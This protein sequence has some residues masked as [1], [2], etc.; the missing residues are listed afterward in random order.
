[1][2]QSRLSQIYVAL[3]SFRERSSL[4]Q[5]WVEDLVVEDAS[6]RRGGPGQKILICGANRSLWGK[7]ELGYTPLN[8]LPRGDFCS[9]IP[10]IEVKEAGRHNK[11]GF[12]RFMWHCHPFG[13]GAP[14]YNNG[15]RILLWEAPP[16]PGRAWTEN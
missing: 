14:S 3:P 2:Q 8:S 9:L 10:C 4:L 11:A 1:M 7:G 16:P 12:L 5:Q 6:W 13:S 15:L